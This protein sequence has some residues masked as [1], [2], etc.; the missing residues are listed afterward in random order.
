M[1]TT[2]VD[3]FRFPNGRSRKAKICLNRGYRLISCTFFFWGKRV[4]YWYLIK[5]SLQKASR[6]LS[7]DTT[8]HR[9]NRRN[10]PSSKFLA[11]YVLIVLVHPVAKAVTTDVHDGTSTSLLMS[12]IRLRWDDVRM[13]CCMLCWTFDCSFWCTVLFSMRRTSFPCNN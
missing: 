5:M 13:G 7:R 8:P 3:L 9:I 12:I 4:L 11:R 1:C 10:T 2:R 6:I